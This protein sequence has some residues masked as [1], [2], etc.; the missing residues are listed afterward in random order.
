[1][2]EVYFMT[3]IAVTAYVVAC[4]CLLRELYLLFP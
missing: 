2:L 3:G 4:A 1:M